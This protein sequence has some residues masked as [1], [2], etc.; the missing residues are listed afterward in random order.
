VA[1][2]VQVYD[3]N[4]NLTSG[5]TRS[6]AWN[7]DN[8]PSRVNDVHLAYGPDGARLSKRSG[9]RTSWYM[10]ADIELTIDSTGTAVWT[11]NPHPDAK[12][13]GLTATF[14]HKDHLNSNRL[15]TDAQGAVITRVSYSPYGEATSTPGPIGA[16][17][18]INEAAGKAHL[19]DHRF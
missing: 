2:E 18:Y 9:T 16:K 17:G 10:G 5:G 4:G 14:L 6:L 12:R 1:G 15:E 7:A 8:Q 19:A 11:K 3:D 13:V